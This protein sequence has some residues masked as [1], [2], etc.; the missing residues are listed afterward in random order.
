MGVGEGMGVGLGLDLVAVVGWPQAASNPSIRA[1][2][3]AFTSK[4]LR[5]L[6]T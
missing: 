1:T 2:A 4:T 3:P 6:A 5:S